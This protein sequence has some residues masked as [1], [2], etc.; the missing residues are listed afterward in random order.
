MKLKTQLNF[1]SL[2]FPGSENNVRPIEIFLLASQ[3]PLVEESLRFFGLQN[4]VIYLVW[5]LFIIPAFW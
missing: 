2:T 1:L 4:I 3:A 5:R